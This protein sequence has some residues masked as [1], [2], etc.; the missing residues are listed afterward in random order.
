[1][2]ACIHTQL[3]T[4][5]MASWHHGIM[6]SWHASLT[7]SDSEPLFRLLPGDVGVHSEAAA[8]GHDALEGDDMLGGREGE[9]TVKE[10]VER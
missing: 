5:I 7:Q 4:V 2:Q 6:A 3:P 1:M 8:V 9:A 10:K